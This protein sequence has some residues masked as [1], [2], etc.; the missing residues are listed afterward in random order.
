MIFGLYSIWSDA[1]PML[2]ELK[3]VQ[4]WPKITMIA[5][6]CRDN[7]LFE[8]EALAIRKKII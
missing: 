7:L 4:V 8:I 2:E 6:V 3:R 5:D 1:L